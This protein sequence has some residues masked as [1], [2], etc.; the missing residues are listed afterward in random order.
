MYKIL[1]FWIKKN[2]FFARS[3]FSHRFRKILKFAIIFSHNFLLLNQEILL[4]NEDF[5]AKSINFV[6]KS[7]LLLPNQEIDL[8][9][10]LNLNV[11]GISSVTCKVIC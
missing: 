8:V 3:L 10:E 9:S 5:V 6:A 4:P 7:R 1:V 2:S 11:N